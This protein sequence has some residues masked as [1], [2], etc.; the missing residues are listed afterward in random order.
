MK[1]PA[2][3]LSVDQMNGKK[4]FVKRKIIPLLGVTAGICLCIRYAE[5]CT[6][7]IENGIL[8]CIEV[9]VPS[10]FL[11]MAVAAYAVK[12]GIADTLT[13]P[14]GG[15]GKALFRL[16]SPALSAIL[17]SMLGGY[18]VGARCASML[19]EEGMLSMSEA[20]K[21]A[22]IAVCAGPGFLLNYVGGALI[23]DRK[24]GLLLLT[25]SVIGVIGNGVVIGKTV[26]TIPYSG[27]NRIDRMERK[28][29]LVSSV[30]DASRSTF[31][32][33]AMVVLCSA[34]IEVIASVSP[35]DH[36][37]DIASAVLEI[38]TG[39]QK[40]CGNYPLPLIA[41]FLGFGGISVHLQIY[42]AVGGLPVRKGLFTLFRL[43]QGIITAV[44]A[45]ILLMVFPV[46][47]T[48]FNSADLPLTPSQS[49]TLAGSAA[50]VFSSLCF[51]GSIRHRKHEVI[52]PRE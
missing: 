14:L 38:T 48:V 32:M 21:T 33:C 23:G 13:R 25:A 26:K 10:L 30:G 46:K 19:Y 50:L 11:F 9:L 45:Y 27:K 31:Q 22:L 51:L 39:C 43:S 6:R 15:L 18:P 47:I 16:P 41:F 7:G 35:D 4:L 49:A 42:A 5:E 3:I 24:A 29:L 2:Y 52:S 28:N 36:L 34:L 17:L 40:M 20:E 8:F 37:T 1:D 44:S 12:S